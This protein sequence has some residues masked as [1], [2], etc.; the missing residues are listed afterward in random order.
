MPPGRLEPRQSVSCRPR[1]CWPSQGIAASP[2]R[3]HRV[4][5]AEGVPPACPW[6]EAALPADAEDAVA[7][8]EE[9]AEQ[10]VQALRCSATNQPSLSTPAKSQPVLPVP[11]GRGG[12]ANQVR[13]GDCQEPHQTPAALAASAALAAAAAAAVA[14]R[15]DAPR[16]SAT[17]R[18]P[19][20]KL[21]PSRHMGMP[22]PAALEA[23]EEALATAEARE[24][25]VRRGLPS[26]CSSNVSGLGIA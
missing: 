17:P 12:R 11:V 20:L 26:S 15:A 7:A 13:P 4:E 5:E 21:R 23:R 19:Q 18:R 6:R 14:A 2:L 16:L 24:S 10:E 9:P 25:V 22:V 1:G 3:W 8:E